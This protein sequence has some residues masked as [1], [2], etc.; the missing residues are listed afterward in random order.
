MICRLLSHTTLTYY[1]HHEVGISTG[2]VECRHFD[3]RDVPV[4]MFFEIAHR[5]VMFYRM[6][7]KNKVQCLIDG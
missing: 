4:S 5:D 6:T 7:S 3:Y 2:V 1:V